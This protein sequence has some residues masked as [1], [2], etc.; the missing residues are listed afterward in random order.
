MATQAPVA[1]SATS[2]VNRLDQNSKKAADLA[3]VSST[4][5][6]VVPA[7]LPQAVACI[8]S[9]SDCW[10]QQADVLSETVVDCAVHFEKA[11]ASDRVCTDAPWL[12][13]CRQHS[14]SNENSIV[15]PNQMIAHLPI[16]WSLPGAS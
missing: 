12:L 4:G 5:C 9:P 2:I 10:G 16:R 3:E 11:K 7:E 14:T 13:F 1:V 15:Y 8:C 6:P